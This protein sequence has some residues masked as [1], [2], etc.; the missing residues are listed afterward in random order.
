MLQLALRMKHLPPVWQVLIIG[1]LT[2]LLSMLIWA[3]QAFLNT[4]SFVVTSLLSVAPV[5]IPGILLA[6]WIAASGAS[7]HVAQAFT[8][9]IGYSIVAASLIGAIT[10]VCGVTVLPLMAGL[11]AGGVP[12]APVMAFWLSSPITDPAMLAATAATLGLSFAI[13]KTLAAFGLGLFGGLL[14]ATQSGKS[15]YRTPLRRNFIVDRIAQPCVADFQAAVWRN[16]DRRRA[17]YREARS[18]SR[19]ILICLIPAFAAEYWLNATLQPEALTAY[20]GEDSWWA[21]PLAVFVG[22]PAYLDGYAALPLVRGL[23]DHGMSPSAAMAFLIS[24]GVISIWGAAAIFPLLRLKPF[25]VYV[26]LACTGSLISG[27]LFGALV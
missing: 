19:L 15:W 13:G 25:M 8:G 9:R 21:V 17:F 24:G 27:W 5:V 12:L 18:I 11:L 6:A 20:L 14:T 16:T 4:S 1:S 3:P 23:M 22:A 10:P 7:S 26:G 2:G